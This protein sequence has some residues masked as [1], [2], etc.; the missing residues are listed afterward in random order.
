MTFT[1][2]RRSTRRKRRAS[3]AVTV[4]AVAL[5][6]AVQ[7]LLP[8]SAAAL[9]DTGPRCDIKIDMVWVEVCVEESAGGTTTGWIVDPGTSGSGSGTNSTTPVVGGIGDPGPGPDDGTSSAQT[10]TSQP[11]KKVGVLGSAL[12]SIR[13]WVK[14]W[15]CGRM[16]ENVRGRIRFRMRREFR[17]KDSVFDQV[18][19]S[20]DS[21]LDMYQRWLREE[22]CN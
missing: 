13:R 16:R 10:S 15:E 1:A 19:G 20:G 5:V 7:A 8:A 11:P 4:T 21:V 18:T 9:A 3:L 2:S 6:G 22:G 12:D 14:Q 17:I